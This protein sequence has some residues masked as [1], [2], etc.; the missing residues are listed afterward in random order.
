MPRTAAY[1]LFALIFYFI[2]LFYLF[3]W[4]GSQRG[5]GMQK[6]FVD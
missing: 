1:V 3:L 6:A 4:E 2:T 5:L